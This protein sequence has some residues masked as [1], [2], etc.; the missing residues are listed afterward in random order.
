MDKYE[1]IPVYPVAKFLTAGEREKKQT[2]APME[3]ISFLFGDNEIMVDLVE[4][5]DRGVSR[6]VGGRGY[7]FACRVSWGQNDQWRT[8]K[9]TIWYDDFLHEWFV[10][11]PESRVPAQRNTAM[12][13]KDVPNHL[14]K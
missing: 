11:V 5:C 3:P 2:P 6:K 7:R 10:E 12:D 13:L 9:S 4:K 8:K 14:E 1:K